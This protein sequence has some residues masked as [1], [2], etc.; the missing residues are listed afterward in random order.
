M[1]TTL[2]ILAAIFLGVIAGCEPTAKKERLSSEGKELLTV[3]FQQGQSL[4]YKFVSSREISVDM[5]ST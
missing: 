2:T 5:D 3:D 1:K 4:Q